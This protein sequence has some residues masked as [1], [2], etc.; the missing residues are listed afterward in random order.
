[1]LWL[2]LFLIA[3]TISGAILTAGAQKDERARKLKDI[4]RRRALLEAKKKP[5]DEVD[6][7]R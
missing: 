7:S 2:I 3:A 5:K 4:E 1:M 6:Q